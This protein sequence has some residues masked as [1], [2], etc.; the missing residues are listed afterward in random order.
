MVVLLA[1]HAGCERQ[2]LLYQPSTAC[3]P[4]SI[5]MPGPAFLPEARD[6]LNHKASHSFAP[7]PS[8][9]NTMNKLTNMHNWSER[10]GPRF[11]MSRPSVNMPP[12]SAPQH[13][14]AMAHGASP[15]ML[16]NP[17]EP[18]HYSF[19]VP[20]ASDLAGPDT[21]DILYATPGAVLRWTHNEDAPDDVPIHELPVHTQHVEDLRKVCKDIT[22][23]P[24]PIEAHV[25]SSEPK[26]VKGQVT[27]VCL[28]GTSEMVHKSR[29]SILN[30]T[31]L[32]L[33]WHTINL[34][35]G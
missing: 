1:W 23:S 16:S 9:N 31:P 2:G 3:R 18:I 30:E 7:L 22:S 19:N 27:T 13:K 33:V 12:V 29:E 8:P 28:S 10:M 5:T 35:D 26:R 17:D 6:S 14:P 32:A 25:K 34:G 4:D 20:F 24:F 15:T 11:G 21:E